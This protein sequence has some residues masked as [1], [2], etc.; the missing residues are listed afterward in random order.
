[1]HHACR[2]RN[3]RGRRLSSPR[4][5][6]RGECQASVWL[7][8]GGGEEG[9]ARTAATTSE[10]ISLLRNKFDMSSALVVPE[11]DQAIMIALQHVNALMT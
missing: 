3:L 4:R 10:L 7:K 11:Q 6:K 5:E 1:M 9:S 2:G 8:R